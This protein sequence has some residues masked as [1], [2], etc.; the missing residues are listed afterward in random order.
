MLFGNCCI[1]SNSLILRRGAFL[2]Q[3]DHMYLENI[4]SVANE[5]IIPLIPTK[6]SAA[7]NRK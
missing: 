6:A 2:T 4:L 3:N 7:P 5:M 1:L